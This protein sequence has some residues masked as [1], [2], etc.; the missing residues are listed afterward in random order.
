MDN[1]QRFLMHLEKSTT[2]VFVAARYLHD[3]GLDV[4]ISAMKKASSHKDWKKFKDDGDLF[5]YKEGEEYRI[6]VKG[7][8]REF[9]GPED[10]KY[11]TMTICA[12]HSFDSADP[13]PYAYMMFNKALTHIAIVRVDKSENWSVKRLQD[14]R[15]DNVFQDFYNCPVKDIQF[16]KI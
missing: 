14:K 13:K 4:R 8:S 12:K 1:H 3:Q 16:I 5:M 15:Y 11:P 9:E 2:A 6:E 7:L 10:I